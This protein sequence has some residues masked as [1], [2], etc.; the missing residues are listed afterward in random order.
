MF[1]KY[2]DAGTES[3]FVYDNSETG[4]GTVGTTVYANDSSI[5][6]KTKA[7]WEKDNAQNAASK[8]TIAA[9]GSSVLFV[10]YKLTEYT[11]YF[12]PG[13]Y[14]YYNTNYDVTASLNGQSSSGNTN[15]TYSFKAKLGQDISS[16]WL[17][18]SNGTWYYG[19]YNVSFSGWKPVGGNTVYVTKRLTLAEDMLPTSGTTITY[20][21]YW[22]SNTV[23]YTV[24]YMLQNA[25]DDDYTRS[26]DYSQ[27]YNYSSGS[28]LSPKDIPGYTYVRR[29]DS[30]NTSNLY[31]DRDK[32]KIDYFYG[33]DNL[34]TIENVKFDA[35]IT[36]NTYNWTPTAEQCGVDSDYTF[37]G[38][39][40]DSG[41]NSLY[42]FSKMPASNL[43][44]YAK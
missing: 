39:Y 42:T 21:G 14:S 8:V 9:D 3:S 41:L 28:S 5:P 40:K 1:E 13:R 25:D 35:T 10:Y 38:W 24:N 43:V 29:T 15:W 32:F 12:R 23:T 17:S 2:N 31:Y 36:S 37:A 20:E 19:Y 26:P 11:F 6:D 7:G 44:L 16:L 4:R 18:A 30:G 33:S 34:K 27:T 22:L